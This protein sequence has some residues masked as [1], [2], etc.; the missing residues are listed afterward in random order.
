MEAFPSID[1]KTVAF[2]WKPGKV[3]FLHASLNSEGSPVKK[4]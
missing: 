3:M 4:K 2:E 1:R